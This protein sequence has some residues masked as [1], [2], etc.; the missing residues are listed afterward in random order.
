VYDVPVRFGS[1]ELKECIGFGG[2]GEVFLT[3][4]PGVVV[5]RLLPHLAADPEFVSLFL[6]EARVAARLHH[7]NIVEIHEL[8]EA[9]GA[10]FLAMEH[11][12]GPDL[13]RLGRVGPEQACRIAEQV[14]AGLDHAHKAR[15]AQGRL[16]R[17]VHRDVSPHNILVAKD[18]TAKLIDFGVARAVG[19]GKPAYL[20][21]EQADGG[22]GDARSD[23]FALGVVLWEL[24][25][26]RRLFDAGDEVAT[27][28]RVTKCEVPPPLRLAGP[29]MRALSKDPK[30]RFRDCAAFAEALR[31]ARE[32][33]EL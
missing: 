9:D 17:V 12:D 20:S 7:P 21:P 6:E 31:S 26:G 2:M 15:D 19:G 32:A 1:Y 3:S 28:Q 29:V 18:G 11:V 10:W 16:L 8:G 24:L 23:Q 25:M 5:K 33:G 14:A 4:K 13:R 30:R 27:L 22:D